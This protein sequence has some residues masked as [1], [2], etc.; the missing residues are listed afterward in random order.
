MPSH[1]LGV[2]A[3]VIIQQGHGARSA[4]H[5]RS[6]KIVFDDE[7]DAEQRRELL[8]PLTHLKKLVAMSRQ[9]FWT[10]MAARGFGCS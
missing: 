1:L 6:V 9:L 2:L 8:I 3:R 10:H 4:R 5:A 7:R